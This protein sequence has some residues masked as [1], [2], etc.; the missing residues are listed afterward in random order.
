VIVGEAAALL[1][2]RPLT[3]AEQQEVAD[4]LEAMPVDLGEARALATSFARECGNFGETP[5]LLPV[6][7]VK[8]GL[9]ETWRTSVV[10][11]P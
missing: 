3:A 1:R 11:A 4:L 9:G 8:R 7:V 6:A 5:T 2:A 10:P